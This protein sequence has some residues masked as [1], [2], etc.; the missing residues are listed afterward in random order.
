MRVLDDGVW[1]EGVPKGVLKNG[2]WSAPKRVC[3]LDGGS[4]KQVWP[5]VK[6][7]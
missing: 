5:T 3:V 4:W 6:K 1:K 7:R 2:T